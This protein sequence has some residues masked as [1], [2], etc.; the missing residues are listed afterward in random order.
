MLHSFVYADCF[1]LWL[2]LW[3]QVLAGAVG[4]GDGQ[5]CEDGWGW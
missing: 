1:K 4:D 5:F 3:G 2:A